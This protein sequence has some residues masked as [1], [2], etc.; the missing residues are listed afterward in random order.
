MQLLGQLR[1]DG[2]RDFRRRDGAEREPRR[3]MDAVQRVTTVTEGAEE[4]AGE[5]PK[6]PYGTFQLTEDGAY[7]E[8][9]KD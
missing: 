8:R 4:E 1:Q 5:A 2:D 6:S 3:A 7:L 9:A